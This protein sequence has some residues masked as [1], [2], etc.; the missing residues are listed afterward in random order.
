MSGADF[1]VVVE[2]RQ[3][4]AVDA[5]GIHGGGEVLGKDWTAGA[6]TGLGRGDGQAGHLDI[7]G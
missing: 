2:H 5:G 3:E 6:H 4:Q 7:H 1:V